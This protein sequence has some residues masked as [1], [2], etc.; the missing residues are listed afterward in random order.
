MPDIIRELP[1]HVANLIAAGEVVQRP[2]S[3]IKEL[4]ENSADAGSKKITVE[5]TD[6]G[7]TFLRVSDDGCGMSPRDAGTAFLRHAT[8]KITSERDLD[9]IV[10]LGFRGE[11]LASVAS[12]SRV[13]LITRERG[14]I[15]GTAVNI[16]GGTITENSP[17]GC[18]EG[19]TIVVRDLFFNTPAR[20]KYVKK[21][22]TEAAAIVSTVQ[23]QAL[24]NTSVAYRLIKDGREVFST[25]G[26]GD[27]RAVIYDVFGRDF[28]ASLQEIKG[29]FQGVALSG[30]VTRPTSSR[31]NRQAQ[32]FI[33]N[34][35]PV[36]SRLLCAALEEGCKTRMPASRFPGCVIC[37]K[38]KP[39]SVDVN[40][41]PAKLEVKFSSEREI[42]DAVYYAVLSAMT[43]DEG[44]PELQFRAAER[45]APLMQSSDRQSTAFHAMSL[46]EYRR[47]LESSKGAAPSKEL[48]YG[49][50]ALQ[51]SATSPSGTGLP[52]E[53][54]QERTSDKPAADVV[55]P[56]NVSAPAGGEAVSQT[57]R[58]ASE[59][60]PHTPAR[61]QGR[62]ARVIGEAF[63][64]YI[65]VEEE[66]GLLLIDKHAAHERILFERLRSEKS[67]QMSQL[68]LAPEVVRFTPKEAQALLSSL[69]DLRASGFEAEDFGNDSLLVRE[70]P[71]CL[72]ACDAQ[73]VL[74]QIAE[75]LLEGKSSAAAKKQEKLLYRVAC[76]AAIKA[77][78]SSAQEELRE[79]AQQVISRED[80]R[81]CP[82]GRPITISI[83]KSAL[84]RQFG[85]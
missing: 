33:V 83:G 45:P 7:M 21:N 16:E 4:C 42:F 22:M 20:M 43:G 8:S 27:L 31:G 13:D 26:S 77:G 48:S 19:T 50:Y 36:R 82:H 6:G 61:P 53:K 58:S 71:A 39:T 52:A 10:T 49:A 59:A 3:V 64:T 70:V 23:E 11:A 81:F 72:D 63:K 28:A 17:A 40:V 75:D 51:K 30:F 29:D 67:G 54:T 32:H 41:H 12:V 84:E 9:S 2:A 5:F 25:S 76:R 44:R 78:H 74:Q 79:L 55:S 24:A 38:T 57:E 62:Q 37:L 80:I 47:L 56:A 73:A 34:N 85:R 15:E 46:E 69:D 68:L 65:I 18:P 35:R 60:L 14:S 66:E 1:E